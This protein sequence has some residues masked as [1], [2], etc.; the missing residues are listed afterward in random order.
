MG[1]FKNWL[2][3]VMYGRYGA[4]ELSRTL[5]FVSLTLTVISIFLR[6]YQYVY[7]GVYSLSFIIL[8]WVLF[9]TFSKNINKR[10]AENQRFVGKKN[11]L[12]QRW[13]DRK[14]YK[15]FNCPKCNT[16]LRVPKGVGIVTITCKK[17]G[18]QFDRKA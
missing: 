14:T 5:I 18:T 11:Y 15:Y 9:R 2:Y 8:A 10:Y 1:K 6:S 3:R 12:K 16:H 4:D 17:C 7:I 13:Q